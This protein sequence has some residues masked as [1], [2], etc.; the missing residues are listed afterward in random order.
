MDT[1]HKDLPSTVNYEVQSERLG[2]EIGRIKFEP[3]MKMWLKVKEFKPNDTRDLRQKYIA[4]YYIS[5]KTGS[6]PVC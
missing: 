6:R 1:R 4:P 5:G 3:G 2:E